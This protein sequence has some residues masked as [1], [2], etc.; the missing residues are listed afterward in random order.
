MGDAY[1]EWLSQ[2]PPVAQVNHLIS[3]GWIAQAIGVAAES[4][5]ADL[6]ADGPRSSIDL[7]QATDSHPQ[8]LY[9]LM[10]A[11]ASVGIFSEVE[12][13][14]FGLTPMADILRSDTPTSLRGRAR[15]VSGDVQ[16]RTWGQL[17]YSVRTGQ[18]AFK[19]VHGMDA[20]TYRA[21]HPEVNAAFNAAMTSITSMATNAVVTAYDFSGAATVADIGGGH[22][23]M[24]VGVLQA[25]PD[26]RGVVFDLPHVV[27]GAEEAVTA[28][29]LRER[30]DIVGGDMFEQ[31]PASLDVYLL[32][33]VVVDW[34]DEHSIA[35]LKNCRR[36]MG[37]DGR[38]LLLEE[39]IPPGDTPSYGKLN[40]LNM[41]VSPGGQG[42]T[43][44]EYCA[45]YEAAGFTLTQIVPTR[46]RMSVIEGRPA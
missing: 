16:W 9:R 45:L 43:E 28:A 6:L 44:A 33:R 14:R 38:L 7:A 1:F 18:P 21:Q 31:V 19:H 39:V 40:D 24:L 2:A 17:R 8:A 20:W 22:G 29:G 26:L 42:R 4:G 25:N 37:P 23:A 15:Q 32:S 41:L 13:E 36:A 35:I 10:R 30:C 46:T 11:L 12:P 34:D 5:I 3:G 27:E